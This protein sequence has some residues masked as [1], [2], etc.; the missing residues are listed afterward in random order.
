MV[1][2]PIDDRGSGF[3]NMADV[4]TLS[5]LHLS[6]YHT[7]AKV[8]VTEALANAAQR[9][10]IVTCDLAQGE[11]CLREVLKGFAYRAWRRPVADADVERLLAVANV[12]KTNG[13][14]AEIGLGLAL[15]AVLLSPHFTLGPAPRQPH[16]AHAP[17]IDRLRACLTAIVFPMEQHAR[18]D[19]ARERRKWRANDDR[20]AEGASST[21]AAG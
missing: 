18:S 3:D 19:P 12:A 20:R 6:V 7:A 15:R 9:A 10:A 5:P 11:A 21:V 14:T 1:I 2:F 8:L 16:V 17:P 4:L 13:D